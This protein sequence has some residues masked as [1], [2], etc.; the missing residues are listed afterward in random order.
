M[1]KFSPVSRRSLLTSGALAATGLGAACSAPAAAPA[2]P[3]KPVS[4]FDPLNPED[5]AY[6]YTKMEGALDGSPNY[7][8]STGYIL[9]FMPG[10]L[11]RQLTGFQQLKVNKIE[12]RGDGTYLDTYSTIYMFTPVHESTLLNEWINPYNDRVT[13]PFHYR[14]GPSKLLITPQGFKSPKNP[15]GPGTPDPF[16]LPWLILSD[17]AHRRMN[18]F[19]WFPS[20]LD[21]ET[22]PLESP[23]E[24]MISSFVTT[25]TGSL[26]DLG[27]RDLLRMDIGTFVS[28][29]T[30]WL[31]WMLMGQQTGHI[32]Y[33]VIGQVYDSLDK[34]PAETVGMA[35][36][37]YPG[38]FDSPFDLPYT[39]QFREYKAQREPVDP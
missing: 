31:P 20:D 6:G 16:I 4:N 22:W 39:L 18:S 32:G 3:P 7:H 12:D 24:Q 15:D 25:A 23:G 38:F 5:N 17:Q 28:A 21:V 36:T 19:N 33:H 10:E 2:P 37:V 9:G 11:P 8:F 29:Q 1:S 30:N 14:S 35:E 27:N 13:R 26:E 34:I